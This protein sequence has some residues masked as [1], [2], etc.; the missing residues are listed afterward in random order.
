MGRCKFRLELAL[1]QTT[2]E[3]RAYSRW[4]TFRHASSRQKCVPYVALGL[5]VVWPPSRHIVPFSHSAK[6]PSYLRVEDCRL[7]YRTGAQ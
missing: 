5:F 3:A 4:P 6:A 1:E 2:L 7:L